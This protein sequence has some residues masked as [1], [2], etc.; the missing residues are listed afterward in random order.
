MQD[1]DLEGVDVDECIED[2]HQ[3]ADERHQL[4]QP[5]LFILQVGIVVVQPLPVSPNGK[6]HIYREQHIER[7]EVYGDH[8]HKRSVGIKYL[9]AH[10]SQ[11]GYHGCQDGPDG[12]P[13]VLKHGQQR[14]AD[15]GEQR[16]TVEPDNHQIPRRMGVA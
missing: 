6:H 13:A 4:A 12:S 9:Q 15:G 16:Y 5:Y 1:V 10:K 14:A 3:Q 7:Q 11:D 2:E 8:R